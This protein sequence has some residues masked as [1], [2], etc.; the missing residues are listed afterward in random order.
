MHQW[1]QCRLPPMVLTLKKK[2][3]PERGAG[4]S[5]EGRCYLKLVLAYGESS[6]RAGTWGGR[7]AARWASKARTPGDRRAGENAP[8]GEYAGTQPISH[9]GLPEGRKEQTD[10][11][12]QHNS[13]FPTHY[14][15]QA[16]CTLAV[17]A[18]DSA[19]TRTKRQMAG[20]VLC[21]WFPR[22][23]SVALGLVTAPSPPATS[24]LGSELY[25]VRSPQQPSRERTGIIWWC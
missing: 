24:P 17:S 18:L 10:L 15:L 20:C 4:I 7:Q 21:P 22:E 6:I 19:N 8:S 12:L 5:G 13:V 2:R 11:I 9:F 25:K 3:R 23:G 1:V 16:V 14:L